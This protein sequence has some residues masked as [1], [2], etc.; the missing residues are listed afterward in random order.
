MKFEFAWVDG[1]FDTKFTK[2]F[3]MNRIFL[4]GF[5]FCSLFIAAGS[6]MDG[7]RLEATDTCC[8]LITDY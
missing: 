3:R 8:A 6:H 7:L 1:I 4:V 2:L 5:K